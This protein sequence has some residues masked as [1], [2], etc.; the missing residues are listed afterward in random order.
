[1]TA[2]LFETASMEKAI[3]QFVYDLEAKDPHIRFAAARTFADLGEKDAP[4][5]NALIETL[6]D[7]VWFVRLSCNE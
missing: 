6:M 4:V 5:Y 2:G 7:A 1:M 3:V